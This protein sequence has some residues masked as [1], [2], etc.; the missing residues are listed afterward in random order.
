[1]AMK[2]IVPP[3]PMYTASRPK[4]SREAA[5]TDDASHSLT[6]GAL[7][8]S[9]AISGWKPTRAPLGGSD[10][11]SDL[12]LSDA[13]AA[14]VN[15][16]KDAL[17]EKWPGFGEEASWNTTFFQMRFVF[18]P[19]AQIKIGDRLLIETEFSPGDPGKGE[20]TQNIFLEKSG[21]KIANTGGRVLIRT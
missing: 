4:N 11:S 12:S 14:Y 17:K 5:P 10:S 7:Q 6:V 8:P 20:F 18:V 16:R 3:S 15:E 13:A 1:M 9:A 21:K 19:Y 2:G